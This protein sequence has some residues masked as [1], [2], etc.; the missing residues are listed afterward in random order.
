MYHQ[1]RNAKT[2]PVKSAAL[3]V[4]WL[5]EQKQLAP[6]SKLPKPLSWPL[7]LC[8][9][10]RSSYFFQH[11]PFPNLLI[12]WKNESLRIG[13]AIQKCSKNRWTQFRKSNR[14]IIGES[15][16]RMIP[17][18]RKREDKEIMREE[19]CERQQ[20]LLNSAPKISSSSSA[21]LTTSFLLPQS[22][23]S[24]LKMNSFPLTLVHY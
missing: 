10:Q 1:D 21:T 5:G 17:S 23:S 6:S 8:I 18:S 12:K 20:Q 14:Q 16:S 3:E 13:P 11:K 4:C 9:P 2:P 7:Y 19:I 15:P 24:E 22:S